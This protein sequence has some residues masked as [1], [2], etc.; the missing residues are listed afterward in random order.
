MGSKIDK[1]I[2]WVYILDGRDRLEINKIIIGL[3]NIIIEINW[4]IEGNLVGF[5]LVRWL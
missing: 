2:L 1:K 3:D 5:F 4:V